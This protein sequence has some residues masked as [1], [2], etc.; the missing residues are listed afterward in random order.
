M[1][2]IAHAEDLRDADTKA[3]DAVRDVLGSGLRFP[4]EVAKQVKELLADPG[5]TS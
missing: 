3:A 1:R 5:T 2:L 4:L